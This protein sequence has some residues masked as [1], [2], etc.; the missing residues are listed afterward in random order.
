MLWALNRKKQ[1]LRAAHER[2]ASFVKTKRLVGRVSDANPHGTCNSTFR[3]ARPPRPIRLWISQCSEPKRPARKQVKSIEAS[4]NPQGRRQ[5]PRSAREIK[6]R[7]ALPV[8]LHQVN[9]FERFQ[10]TNQNAAAN[11]GFFARNIQHEMHAIVEIHV[12]MSMPQ[13]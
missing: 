6:Q 5:P 2:T 11:A 9:S 3:G 10:R 4:V 1:P 8:T 12:N 13:E 7:L